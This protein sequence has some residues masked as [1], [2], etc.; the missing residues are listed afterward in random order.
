M[1]TKNNP[2]AFDC[3]ANAD[4]DEPM[5][6]LLARDKH[7]PALVWIWAA[8]RELDSEDPAKVQE[9][10]ECVVAMMTWAVDHGR[11]TAGFGQAL[12]AGQLELIRTINHLNHK[13]RPDDIKNDETA[14][15]FV[16]RML[17]EVSFGSKPE[18]M[19]AVIAAEAEAGKEV[20]S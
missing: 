3:Y 4:P 5:F 12:L 15:D 8:L 18:Q 11:K 2:G 20:R 14:V 7:A 13:L 9:A 1:G 17:A 16:R 19:A 10:R 6:I